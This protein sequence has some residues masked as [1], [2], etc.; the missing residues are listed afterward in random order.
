MRKVFPAM[1]KSRL[2]YVIVS[3]IVLIQCC[4]EDSP[5]NLNETDKATVQTIAEFEHFQSRAIAFARTSEG[6]ASFVA[7]KYDWDHNKIAQDLQHIANNNA[8]T[9]PEAVNTH[10]KEI[11]DEL[12]KT[13]SV[14]FDDRYLS[15]SGEELQTIL[16]ALR[17]EQRKG[18]EPSVLALNAKMLHAIERQ[19]MA[20]DSILQAN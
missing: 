2:L 13:D 8:L 19:Y 10:H 7:G 11:L 14:N 3:N 16:D 15:R 17:V 4:P 1:R 6:K 18:A 12:E 9:L 20:V 5:F